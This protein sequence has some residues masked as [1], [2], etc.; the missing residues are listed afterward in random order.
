MKQFAFLMMTSSLAVC[1]AMAQSGRAA[2]PIVSGS[3]SVYV[4]FRA[5][6]LKAAEK[7]PEE[8]YAFQPAP[9]VRT[10]GRI[11]GHVANSQ[12][13]FCSTA[14]GEKNPAPADIE[15]TKTAK[16]DLVAA[17]KDSFAYCDKIYAGMTDSSGAESVKFFGR[18]VSRIVVLNFNTAHLN[19]HYG[20]IVT[21][22][23]LKGLEPPSSEPAPATK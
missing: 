22:M 8:N 20:N 2:N 11:V 19:E 10:F 4:L 12:Y 14:A 5:N 23:R 17:L 3:Q 16:E 7:M 9:E 18:D 13:L 6:V 21:Y 1:P 15:K